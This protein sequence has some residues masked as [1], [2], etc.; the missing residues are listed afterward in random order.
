M[1]ILY[2]GQLHPHGVTSTT[3]MRMEELARAGHE[4][5]PLDS[6][7]Y[8]HW[9][10]RYVGWPVRRLLWG[11]P[12]ARLNRDLL[13]QAR[14]HRPEMLW[15]DKG[16]WV[17]P[18]TL[19]RAREIGCEVLVHY[20]PDPAFVCHRSRHFIA[21]IP[22]YDLLVTTKAYEVG[23]YRQHGAREVLLQYPSYD[24][25]VHRPCEPTPDQRRIYMADAVFVGTY[26]PG[27]EESL[28]PVARLGIDLAIWGNYWN[29]CRDT[30]LRK[31]VRGGMVGGRDY[32][33]TLVCAKIGLGL[34]SP[35][36]PDRSTTRSLEIPACGTFLLAPRTD[37]HQALFEEGKEAEFFSSAEEMSEKI[38]RYLADDAAREAV[39]AAGRARCLA[40]GYSSADRVR[41]IMD[42]ADQVLAVS[43]PG[44][45]TVPCHS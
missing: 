23:L 26:A 21:S 29:R 37:E 19:R 3:R 8:L 16:V 7:P 24:G 42:R 1:K 41:T 27:R 11:P 13:A 44:G 20:T 15:I 9:G 32:A 30:E 33:L 28:R 14:R 10:G 5:I 12:L 36:C 35:L 4:I 38:R 43:R 17:F 6:I 45:A 22:Q 18:Q 25:D 2:C 31:R 40:S 39:A 34:L